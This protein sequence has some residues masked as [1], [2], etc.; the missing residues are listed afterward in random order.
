[1]RVLVIEDDMLLQRALARTVR[2]AFDGVPVVV[3]TTDSSQGAIALLQANVYDCVLSDFLVRGGRASQV[4]DWLRLHQPH[5]AE[6]FVYLSGAV[7]DFQHDKVIS[8][9]VDVETFAAQLRHFLG[10][11]V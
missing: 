9:G 7:A 1:V 10:I 4:L 8:K 2:S 5:L 3:D 11:T 6:R